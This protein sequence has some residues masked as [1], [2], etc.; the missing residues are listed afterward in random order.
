M[1]EGTTREAGVGVI[2][3]RNLAAHYRQLHVQGC[4]MEFEAVFLSVRVSVSASGEILP[5]DNATP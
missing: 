5:S 3:G 4:S 1:F 2:V